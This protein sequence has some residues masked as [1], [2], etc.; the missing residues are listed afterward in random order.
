MFSCKA[1]CLICCKVGVPVK[2]RCLFYNDIWTSVAGSNLRMFTNRLALIFPKVQTYDYPYTLH[3]FSLH[4][5]VAVSLDNCSAQSTEYV[6][7]KI[8]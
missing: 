6:L 1:R 8:Q 3:L 7:C 4:H 5:F 2:R